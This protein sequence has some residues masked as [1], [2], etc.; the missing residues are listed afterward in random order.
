MSLFV[1]GLL[2]VGLVLLVGGAEVFVRGASRIAAMAGISPLVIGLTVVSLGTSA[3][4]IAVS[5]QSSLAGQG[6]LALGNIVGSNICNVLLILGIAAVIA[7]LYVSHQLIRLD[8]PVMIGIS[9]LVLL[10]ALDGEVTRMEGIILAVGA[11]GYVGFLLAQSR[12]EGKAARADDEFSAA[13]AAP[14]DR[15]ARAWL[16]SL[17]AIAGGLVLLVLGSRWLVAGAVT[18]AEA[19]GVSELIIG[20]TVIAIGTSLPEVATSVIAS[21]KGERDIAVGNAIGS[22]IFNIL[23][24]LGLASI[25]AP[26]GIPVPEAA[27]NFDIPVMIAVA[28]ACLP[29]FATGNLI[30]RWE[31]F[32]FLGYY[33]AYTVYLILA[34]TRHDALPVY[35]LVMM[36]FVIPLTVVTLL[37]VGRRKMR[38]RRA[39]RS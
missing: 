38:Y 37:V 35:S 2:L 26:G 3:P 16:L 29:I 31:G 18:V 19:L 4:E 21:I 23:V 25:V 8:V 12:K 33:V 9:V 30:A 28:I 10:F 36:A 7:P 27:I 13:Y 39:G 34:S 1:L 24:V 6:D 5:V 20:L 14:E 15:S 17:A 11:I 32:V 22:N